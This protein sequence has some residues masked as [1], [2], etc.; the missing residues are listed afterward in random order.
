MP[1][2][3]PPTAVTA[4]TGQWVVDN[5][6]PGLP[7]ETSDGAPLTDA[8]IDGRI[9]SVV[10]AF[11]RKYGVRLAPTVVK[12]G[13]DPLPADPVRAAP[14]DPDPIRERYRGLDYMHDGNLDNRHHSMK[15]P[16]GPVRRIIGVGLR[17]PGMTAPAALPVDWISFQPRSAHIRLYPNK[18]LS[19]AV[20]YTGGW[21]LNVLGAGRTIPEAWHV[22]YEAGYDPDDLTG[23]DYD[24][25]EA[26]GKMVAIELLVPGSMDR[27]LAEGVGGKT[28][29]ADGLSQSIQLL[30][31]AGGLKYANVIQT[32]TQ[33]LAEWESMF[34]ARRGGVR[35]GIL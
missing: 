22:T 19:F 10:A 33:Q 4:L 17:L 27:F 11:Q 34:W 12:V 6:L 13:S 24:V 28:I 29:S 26:L 25:L 1:S 9:K 30:Q 21:F 5:M 18:T 23:L 14:E 31:H 15:L 20:T 8:L 7:L 16:V 2:S 32:L 3:T 35:I